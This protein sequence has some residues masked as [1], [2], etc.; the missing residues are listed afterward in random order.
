MPNSSYSKVADNNAWKPIPELLI[1]T[2]DLSIYFLGTNNMAFS[3]PINDPW[4]KATQGPYPLDTNL[5]TQEIYRSGDP[6]RPLGCVQRY[7][8]CNPSLEKN[9]SCTPLVG[10]LEAYLLAS[11]TLFPEPKHREAFLW[12]SSAILYMASG[13]TEFIEVLRSEAL[14]ASETVSGI[15]QNALPNNQW[16]LEL[17]HWFKFTLADL[18][19]AILDQAVGPGLPETAQF[20]SRPTSAEAQTVCNSQKIRSDSFTSFNVLGLVLIFSIGGLIMIISAC[21]PWATQRIRRE[22]KLYAGLEWITNDTLQLQRL[23]HEAVGAGRWEGACD[24]YPRTRKDDLLAAL[25]ITDR[26]HPVLRAPREICMMKKGNPE[27]DSTKTCDSTQASLWSVDIPRVKTCD[28]AQESLLSVEIPRVSL[29]L[30]ERL[31]SMRYS[32]YV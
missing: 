25:D 6:A 1:P 24:D 2:A 29:D 16:E 21:L 3:A 17:E 7:Q 28:S 12:S 8:F 32:R 9:S 23:A 31:D 13:F 19:R 14:R 20:H 18:Q 5:G 26:K 10:I 4:F 11:S 27:E 22:K 15:G 30:K